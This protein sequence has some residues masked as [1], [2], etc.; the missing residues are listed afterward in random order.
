MAVN[1]VSTNLTCPSRIQRGTL[2]KAITPAIRGE[3]GAK[4][5]ACANAQTSVLAGF[6][7]RTLV[8]QTSDHVC[9]ESIDSAL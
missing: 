1:M 6:E 4:N 5:V 7:K 8:Q 2:N 3:C 9:H